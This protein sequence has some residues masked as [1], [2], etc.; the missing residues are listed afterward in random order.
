[1]VVVG[2]KAITIIIIGLK[3]IYIVS[4][5]NGQQSARDQLVINNNLNPSLIKNLSHF[6]N[7]NKKKG[8]CFI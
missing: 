4:I 1:M 7:K 3:H 5:L 2:F 6:K 8:L